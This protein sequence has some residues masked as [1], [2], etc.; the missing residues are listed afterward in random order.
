MVHTLFCTISKSASFVWTTGP[1]SSVDPGQLSELPA[2]H[3][4]EEA[5]DITLLLAVNFLHI[6]VGPHG[7]S[8]PNARRAEKTN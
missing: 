2:P 5:H 6:L 4:D 8:L 1:A 3:S 7:D